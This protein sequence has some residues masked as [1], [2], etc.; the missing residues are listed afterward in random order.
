M[1]EKSKRL[2]L[3][4]GIFIGL[5]MVAYAQEGSSIYGTVTDVNTGRGIAGIHVWLNE[6]EDT[7]PSPDVKYFAVTSLNG[8]YRITHIQQG[9]YQFRV[10]GVGYTSVAKTIDV[11]EN[12]EMKIDMALRERILYLDGVTI[13]SLRTERF[14]RQSPFPTGVIRSEDIVR[15]PALTMPD[16]MSYEPGISLT[17]DGIWATSVNIRGLSDQRI[18]SLIDGCRIETATDL[19]GGLSMI[20]PSDIERVEVIKGAGSALY[21]SGAMG[22]VVNI[23]TKDAY[24]NGVPYLSGTASTGYH[25]V[26][27]LKFGS[28][29]LYTGSKQWKLKLSGTWRDAG[30][31]MTPSGELANSQFADNSLGIRL[32]IKTGSNKEFT[33][34]GQRFY[35][36][37]VG[38]P[39][40]KV[41]GS[42]AMVTYP[43]E[44]RDLASASYAIHYLFPA[45]KTLSIKY[46][47]Q[48][49]L[50]DTRADVG[51]SIRATPT[52]RHLTNG[53]QVQSEWEFSD[54]HQLTAGMEAWQRILRTERENRRY[55]WIRNSEGVIVDTNTVIRG[56]I[57]I[58]ESSFLDA[59]F[60]AQ[61]EYALV[62]GKLKLLT[63]GRID[64]ITVR[65]SEGV[66][67]LYIINNGVRNDNP[68]GQKIIFRSHKAQEYTW[69]L[70]SGLLLTIARNAELAVNLARSFRAPSLEERFKYIM[71]PSGMVRLGNPDLKSEEG[72]FA[73]GG[74]R[75]WGQKFT[76]KVN[77]FVNRLNDLVVEKPGFFLYSFTSTPEDLDTIPALV[78]ANV[79]KAVLYGTDGSF[80]WNPAGTLILYGKYAWVIGKDISDSV[81]ANLPQIAPMN[82][83]AGMRYFFCKAGTIELAVQMAAKQ[84]R[85]AVGEKIT[86]GYA[87]YNAGFSTVPLPLGRINAE[88]DC[89]VQNI[90]NRSYRNHLATNR[91][92][93]KDEP[94]RNVYV[95]LVLRF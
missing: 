40:G 13:T 5:G 86:G 89:G 41:F 61:D 56:E 43:K 50:R 27:G 52:G 81:S 57:P 21:G 30:N 74:F 1:R 92:I 9:T 7:V 70:H 39:G 60:F 88:L 84:D 93:I 15:M 45:L 17:R 32:G 64:G 29:N 34:D 68:S 72:W 8:E 82:G 4:L 85:I 76:L 59:G 91:G 47:V 54:R 36:S 90:F 23:I 22:G 87:V 48:Y 2:L 63:G 58:P 73:D 11:P 42:T 78:N 66:D 95:R 33:L 79:S 69:S 31:T 26:N 94:G 71:L 53:I 67:P 28:L 3:C 49:I 75:F 35:A 37:N 46:Y 10:S 83:E 14:V 44:E 77:G 24:Y 6:T 65:N 16:M 51:D 62:P 55:F 80:S 12:K 19:A 38:L 18:I 20:D 25:Q